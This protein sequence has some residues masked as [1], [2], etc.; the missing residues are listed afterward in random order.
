MKYICARLLIAVLL[1]SGIG[2]AQVCDGNANDTAAIQARIDV[3]GEVTLPSGIC[4]VTG[5][6]VSKDG[7]TLAG[8][9]RT[10]IKRLP[11][12]YESLLSLPAKWGQNTP[13]QTVRNVTIRGIDF[14]GSMVGGQPAG[15]ANFFGIQV[16][17]GDNITIENVTIHDQVHEGISVCCGTQAVRNIVIRDARLYRIYRNGIHFGYVDGGKILNT[18]IERT[19]E[20]YIWGRSSGNAVDIEVEGQGSYVRNI[21]I[22]GNTFSRDHVPNQGTAGTGVALQPAYGPISNVRITNNR[23]RNHPV[24]VHVND[25]NRNA[26]DTVFVADNFFS[27]DQLWTNAYGGGQFIGARN[28]QY[29]R[30][31]LRFDAGPA[32][33]SAAVQISGVNGFYGAHNKLFFRLWPDVARQVQPVFLIQDSSGVWLDQNR[34][35]GSAAKFVQQTGSTV[36]ET[37]NV[38]VP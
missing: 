1:S 33:M 18:T 11:N 36:T 9:G 17:H 26:V 15:L 16:I 21:V 2:F 7:T 34:Y 20:Q 4:A 22:D 3:G 6:V 8:R 31:E 27:T 35:G 12:T 24:P 37:N 23:F 29:L 5:L 38:S 14:D 30:N 28:I 13:G 25:S 10:V 32:S 19:P